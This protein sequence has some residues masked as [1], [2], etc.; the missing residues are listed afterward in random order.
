METKYTLKVYDQNEKCV[1]EESANSIKSLENKGFKE[2]M[3]I[4][5]EYASV[6]SLIHY[7]IFEGSEEIIREY[8]EDFD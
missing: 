6:D 5:E 3:K 8:A 4:W 7:S 1:L 2:M